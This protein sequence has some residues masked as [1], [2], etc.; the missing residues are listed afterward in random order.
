MTNSSEENSP[1]TVALKD[2]DYGCILR[3]IEDGALAE[4]AILTNGYSQ[5]IDK[6]LGDT[7]CKHAAATSLVVRIVQ[8]TKL[9]EDV[10][11]RDD[12]NADTKKLAMLHLQRRIRSLALN[13]LPFNFHDVLDIAMKNVEIK[14][15]VEEE[16]RLVRP[17]RR[18]A[19][20]ID[21]TRKPLCLR[22]GGYGH[23]FR[24]CPDYVCCVCS[25]LGP[26]HLAV[27][28]PRLN[29]QIVLQ[30]FRD[31]EK[32]FEALLEWEKNHVALEEL[33][34][35]NPAP[36]SPSYPPELPSMSAPPALTATME[37]EDTED[38]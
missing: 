20:T 12:L 32:F 29:G 13:L 22:C 14:P 26:N 36:R 28:C 30:E 31:E 24:K 37:E 21:R 35:K 18:K 6:I 10:A 11:N 25:E 27:H 8:T 34:L 9:L 33:I 23:T 16:P 15:N 19:A 3:T 7:D 38:I 5:E 1:I 4:A 17:L 2:S